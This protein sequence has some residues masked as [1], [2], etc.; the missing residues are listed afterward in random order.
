[1]GFFNGTH[2]TVQAALLAGA[3]L[4]SGAC[5]KGIRMVAA[6]VPV[7]GRTITINF[8]RAFLF[9]AAEAYERGDY[10]AAG[11]LFREALRRQLWSECEWHGILPDGASERTPPRALLAAAC[12]GGRCRPD[13]FDVVREMVRLANAT[14]HCLPFRPDELHSSILLLFDIIDA[15]PYQ[16]PAN[17]KGKFK[18]EPQFESGDYSRDDCDDDDRRKADW[19]K[20]EGWSP[21][22]AA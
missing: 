22:G 4:F 2:R 3:A 11:V 15:S 7:L 1:M 10:I 9:R 17:G 19:W 6:A 8:S 21:G 12:K 13:M 5:G 20:P 14:A 16:Q 18:P